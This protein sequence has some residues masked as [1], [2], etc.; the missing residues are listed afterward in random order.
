MM[1]SLSPD[2]VS[3][4]RA[5]NATTLRKVAGSSRARRCQSPLVL[6]G[7]KRQAEPCG[8][9]CPA[10]SATCRQRQRHIPHSMR[11]KRLRRT[12]SPGRTLRRFVPALGPSRPA[13]PRRRR[14][15]S[16]PRRPHPGRCPTT[17]ARSAPPSP[18][19]CRCG[20]A[21]R[22]ESADAPRAT[23]RESARRAPGSACRPATRSGCHDGGSRG[24]R[25]PAGGGRCR[26]IRPGPLRL[27]LPRP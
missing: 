17:S 8:R 14:S 9:E 15:Q 16:T 4:L 25:R 12:A 20:R 3:C 1:L 19:R 18:R 7:Q 2:E 10:R 27:R 6:N 11:G 5:S 22:R 23:R 24:G 13:W 26:A 21:W